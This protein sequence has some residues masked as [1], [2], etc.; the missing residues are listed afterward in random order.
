MTDPLLGFSPTL[1]ARRRDEI[2]RRLGRGAMILPAAPILHRYGNSELPY[3]P[4]AELFYV[5]GFR[6]PDALLLL[7]GH[8]DEERV[9][10]FV[11]D[12]DPEAE[13][14]GGGRL[15]PEGA[16]EVTGIETVLSRSEL[17]ERL[18]NLVRDTDRLH[19][20]LG[21]HPEVDRWVVE[22]LRSARIGGGK[23]GM[24]PR[25]VTDPGEILDELRLRKDP[26][27]VEAIRDAARFTMESFRA[28]IP[29]V[30]PGVG[31]WEVQAALEG[32]FR[33]R[34]GGAPAFSTIV[35]SGPNACTLHY[36]E[37]D[38]RMADGE[39]LLMDA[40]AE[41]RLYGGDVT[42]T[43][44][45]GGRFSPEQ[46]EL[47]QVVEGARRRV[48]ELARP[49]VSLQSLHR[50]AVRCLVTGMVA[51]GILEGE[52]EELIEEE[53]HRRY[54]PHRTSHWL[55]LETHDPGDYMVRGEE[56]LLEPGM[57]FTVEPGLYLPGYGPDPLPAGARPWAD[58]G[59][60]IEDDVLVTESGCELLTGEL[61]TDLDGVEALAEG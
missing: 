14:W 34:G 37:N 45:V 40:G 12:R 10:L 7:R 36:V 41:W 2:L 32:E 42:R 59:I 9:I 15:G 26:A 49:G 18:P 20:R 56:R 11:R 16:R 3:R 60:R 61:P 52:P 58:L 1:F 39:L 21:I 29:H 57:V 5:C 24:G 28:A 23:E 55:G 6:E 46:R 54:F 48:V 27:E 35:G 51:L 31:E 44:P 47:Y 8:A 53:A 50:E 4:D 33:R 17:Q 38:R 43:I 30:G 25:G 19:H 22:A 13:R